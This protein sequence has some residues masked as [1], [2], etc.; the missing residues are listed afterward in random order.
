MPSYAIYK[1]YGMLSQF[2]PEQAGQITLSDLE[3][4][5]SKD[6]YPVGR[7]DADSEGLLLLT[8]DKAL[9]SKILD[10]ENHT[11]K[12][13]LVQVEGI[14]E[15]SDLDKLRKGVEIR[16][17]GKSH[18][19]RPASVTMPDPS[20]ALPPRTPPVR[21][22]KTV[23]DCWLEIAIDEGKNR[24]VRRMC[25]AVGFPVL[26]LVRIAIGPIRLGEAPLENMAPGA[27]RQLDHLLIK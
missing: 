4:P 17:K 6:V 20:P 24:Q 12:T 23:P 13:Y 9:V 5:F 16:I 2:T 1:P 10:P 15:E 26:R 22:R 25:A 14:P 11:I 8:N 27:V 3:Y 7:L 21:F 18:R 19:T